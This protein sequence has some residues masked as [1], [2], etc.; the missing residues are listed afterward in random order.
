LYRRSAIE[1]VGYLSD[2]NL[3]GAEEYELALRLRAKGWRL[4]RLNYPSIEHFGH[5]LSTYRLLWRRLKNKQASGLG[6]LAR[7]AYEAGNLRRILTEYFQIY[8]ALYGLLS[9]IAI[10]TT[11]IWAPT[12][13]WGI[14]MLLMIIA[15]PMIAMT[16]RLRSF[17]SGMYSVVVWH[18]SALGFVLGLFHE[19]R[20]PSQRIRSNVLRTPIS[21]DSAS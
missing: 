4:V 1:Q 11:P 5:Q 13:F 21:Q 17:W 8:F 7:A 20:P 12:V 6:E 9:W 14:V 10:V 15:F 2:R 16:L 19:R 3:H 18:V